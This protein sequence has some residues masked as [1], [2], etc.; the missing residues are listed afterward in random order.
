MTTET[1]TITPEAEA[2]AIQEGF[3][4]VF[5]APKDAPTVAEVK[6][7]AAALDPAVL[8]AIAKD[9]SLVEGF[10]P[11]QVKAFLAKTTEIDKLT[12]AFEKMSGRVG[13]LQEQV[14]ILKAPKEPAEPVRTQEDIEAAY[15]ELL[16]FLAQ[17]YPASVPQEVLDRIASAE[18]RNEELELRIE[19]NTLGVLH[20]DWS[21]TLESDAYKLWL[22]TQAPEVQKTALT[23]Y[24]AMELAPVIQSF[25]DF[26][27]KQQSAQ[28]NKERAEAAITPGSR[29][30]APMPAEQ[31]EMD[32]FLSVFKKPAMR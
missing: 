23:T 30:P 24:H 26:A 11:E 2:A 27:G 31:T 18:A 32:A 28:R 3:D 6:P 13:T 17:K 12:S 10:T 7:E 22:A 5:E 25:K 8:E 19:K 21:K 9:E 14:T 15:P 4:S 16:P 29:T 20:P 1:E